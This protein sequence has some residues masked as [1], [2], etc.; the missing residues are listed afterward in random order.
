M[1]LQLRLHDCSDLAVDT[2]SYEVRRLIP[3]PCRGRIPVHDSFSDPFFVSVGPTL[4]EQSVAQ[5]GDVAYREAR[6][7]LETVF[8][9]FGYAYHGG[10]GNQERSETQPLGA[11]L[12]LSRL[13]PAHITYDV[14]QVA[15]PAGIAI[16]AVFTVLGQ[17]WVPESALPKGLSWHASTNEALRA[18]ID[19]EIGRD[20]AIDQIDVY[21]DGSY[22]GSSSWAFVCIATSSVGR[23]VLAWARGTVVL[24]GQ[25]WW[26]GAS[27]HSALNGERSAVFWALCWI[28]GVRSYVP[29]FLHCDCIVAAFQTA[30]KYGSAQTD[31]LAVACRSLAH[32][33]TVLG[34]L[35]AA[36]IRHV[37]GH[38]GHPYNELADVLAGAKT[39]GSTSLPEHLR[40]Y[41]HCVGG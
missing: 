13:L 4:L 25:E 24:S 40:T 37:K 7:V 21:T 6:A 22:D 38:S 39:V 20:H 27:E 19:V 5:N 31:A 17:A 41:G 2:V 14:S 16:D 10:D 23:W 26:I 30:G 34:K 33:L 18:H 9:H 8:E 3:T 1:C 12:Y 32:V 36:T 29:C 28:L 11:A 35:D 15:M